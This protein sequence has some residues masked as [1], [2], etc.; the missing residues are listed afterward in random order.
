MAIPRKQIGWSNESNLLWQISSQLEKL[1]GVAYNSG[2]GGV[3]GIDTVLAQ[4]QQLTSNRAIDLNSNSLFFTDK[5]NNYAQ[6]SQNLIVLGDVDGAGSGTKLTINKNG[7]IIKT[8]HG[9]N[10]KGVY[11]DFFNNSYQ[12]GDVANSISGAVLKINTNGGA[13]SFQTFINNNVKGLNIDLANTSYKIGDFVGFDNHTYINVDD[14]SRTTTISGDNITLTDNSSGTL[15][16]NLAGGDSGLFLVVTING[17]PYKIQ[18]F[19][20]L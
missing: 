7:E 2:G 4:N 17:T 19:N 16:T 15:T 8:E 14:T 20:N 13:E 12:F 5:T 6:F 3:A 10:D 1:T 18:L 11:L 9:G